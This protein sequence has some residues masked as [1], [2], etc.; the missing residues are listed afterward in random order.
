MKGESSRLPGRK[1]EIHF[2]KRNLPD[3]LTLCRLVTGLVVVTLSIAGEKAYV[4]VVVL[5]DRKMLDE[6]EIMQ[7]GQQLTSLVAGADSPKV[8]IDFSN[9][10]HMSSS[11]L[12][13]LIT[14]HK[15]ICEKHGQLR[16][17][18]IKPMIREVF[19]ITRLDEIF[20]I[21]PSRGEAMES[22]E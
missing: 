4:T 19:A 1:A 14:L 22:I 13:M 7:I 9:V 11:A 15:H 18:N 8:I 16:L 17:C 12:G 5:T 20:R 3:F 6:I 2:I 21:L 10:D